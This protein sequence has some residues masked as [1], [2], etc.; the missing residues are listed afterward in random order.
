MI[1]RLWK[2]TSVCRLGSFSAVLGLS[3]V[4]C[5]WLLL[6]CC[7]TASADV[8]TT[9]YS[10]IDRFHSA[11]QT[12]VKHCI[13]VIYSVT[14]AR[15]S[16][17]MTTPQDKEVVTN[18]AP[19]MNGA[20]PPLNASSSRK[21][22]N[23]I[24]VK[25]ILAFLSTLLL[26]LLLGGYA[27]SSLL[28]SEYRTVISTLISNNQIAISETKQE[29]YECHR[30]LLVAKEAHSKSISNTDDT[31]CQEELK[32]LQSQW[33][34]EELSCH[35]EMEREIMWSHK[36]Y[37]DSTAA[38]RKA[39][40]KLTR[41]K[42]RS[43]TLSDELERKQT[44]LEQVTSELNQ[45]TNQYAKD[46]VQHKQLEAEWGF[47]Q[48]QFQE[49]QTLFSSL[50]EEMERRDLERA[51]C[52]KTHRDMMQCQQSLRQTLEGKTD[53]CTT[54]LEMASREKKELNSKIASVEEQNE[55]IKQRSNHL[56]AQLEGANAL[57]REFESER[58]G[59]RDEIQKMQSMISEKDR[60][61]VLDR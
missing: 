43:V 37:Q 14:V 23:S 24:S 25:Q 59:L 7:C 50:E 55:S 10:D 20:A 15:G 28:E 42:E 48:S 51:E 16:Q 47:V 17:R 30:D 22:N 1:S 52:D 32:S 61:S 41:L 44:Q 53:G 11:A 2:V 45:T 26:G 27:T 13:T 36:A 6:R 4:R 49:M 57:V 46:K 33:R 3:A 12:A 60:L 38:L 40:E 34:H 39:G 35:Q 8:T 18:T 56:D 54:S 58:N 31:F 29:H 21:S 9:I 5:C 19:S